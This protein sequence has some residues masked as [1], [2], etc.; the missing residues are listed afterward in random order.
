MCSGNATPD[1]SEL[2]T[3]GL[4]RSPVNIADPLTEVESCRIGVVNA[5]KLDQRLVGSLD[6]SASSESEEFGLD[7]K[8]DGSLVV[9][10][11]R[12]GG[13]LGFGFRHCG[14]IN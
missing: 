5:L 10:G 14:F 4:G 3:G 9:F 8:S 1:S 6:F 12:G 7:P 13:F 2:A 11:C